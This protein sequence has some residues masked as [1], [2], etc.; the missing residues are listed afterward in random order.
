MGRAKEAMLLQEEADAR[1]QQ[2]DEALQHA[3]DEAEALAD[4]ETERLQFEKAE[5]AEAKVKLQ[6]KIEAHE[7]ITKDDLEYLTRPELILLCLDSI[8][9]AK[10][11]EGE[12]QKWSN[13]LIQIKGGIL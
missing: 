12:A 10:F 2:E 3:A 5:A 7:V 1:I 6:A 13:R 4:A 9:R 8:E 11:L